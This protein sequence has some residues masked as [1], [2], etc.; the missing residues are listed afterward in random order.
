M[1]VLACHHPDLVVPGDLTS[2]VR[3]HYKC[4]GVRNEVVEGKE[5]VTYNAFLASIQLTRSPT[6]L[7]LDT[8]G[9]CGVVWRCWVCSCSC[10]CL[11]GVGWEFRI[12]RDIIE[13]RTNM[14]LQIATELH[15]VRPGNSRATPYTVFSFGNYLHE[16]GGYNIIHRAANGACQ[17]CMEVLLAKVR[18]GEDECDQYIDKA[19]MRRAV[20]SSANDFTALL[21][22][23]GEGDNNIYKQL[24]NKLIENH[25]KP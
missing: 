18:C 8:E 24:V 19:E 5:Y 3:I 7:R 12:L 21:N 2:R 16:F 14:P 10:K 15:L 11:V 23:T 13:H 20:P 9:K 22:Q 1:E 25:N 17:S 4:F 6:F